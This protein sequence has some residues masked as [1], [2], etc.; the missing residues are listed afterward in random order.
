[1]LPRGKSTHTAGIST[2]SGCP[3]PSNP[4]GPS[5]PGVHTLR[6]PRVMSPAT[7]PVGSTPRQGR[8][9]GREGA[10]I[11]AGVGQP[12]QPHAPHRAA[13]EDLRGAGVD[14]PEPSGRVAA[15]VEQ[16]KLARQQLHVDARRATKGESHLA[17]A[18]VLP[19]LRGRLARGTHLPLI[20]RRRAERQIATMGILGR[21]RAEA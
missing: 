6:T 20:E 14:V 17:P 19:P 15:R 12:A 7:A 16:D 3:D 4:P 9:V 21:P 5:C 1:M 11:E 18:V 10:D 8:V 2:V 13:Q